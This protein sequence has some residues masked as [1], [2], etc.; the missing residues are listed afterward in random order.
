MLMDFFTARSNSDFLDGLWFTFLQ[1]TT[2]YEMSTAILVDLSMKLFYFL[3][4]SMKSKKKDPA[5]KKSISLPKSL[6]RAAEIRCAE[7]GRTMSSYIS[8]LTAKDVAENTKATA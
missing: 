2:E 6:F 5:V 4:T 8:R 7:E 3:A 1:F